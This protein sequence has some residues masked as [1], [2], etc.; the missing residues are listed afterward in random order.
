M[1]NNTPPDMHN[2]RP[3]SPVFP[4]LLIKTSEGLT[5]IHHEQVLFIHEQSGNSTLHLDKKASLLIEEPL[6]ELRDQLKTYSIFFEPSKGYLLNLLKIERL[7]YGSENF[8]L[9]SNGKYI[10]IEKSKI[11]I[12]L[13][14]IKHK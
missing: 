11:K 14:R 3:T 12:L 7:I 9:M 13:N 5:F 8:L 6:S 10:P 2:Q 4:K 1:L